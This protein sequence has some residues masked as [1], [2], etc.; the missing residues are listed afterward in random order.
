MKNETSPQDVTQTIC[1][2]LG[3]EFPSDSIIGEPPSKT[4]S[5][6]ESYLFDR[7]YQF[8]SLIASKL[9]SSV[10]LHRDLELQRNVVIKTQ[11]V[12]QEEDERERFLSECRI[13]AAFEHPG[14]IPIYDI[15]N[16]PGKVRLVMRQVE[17]KTLLDWLSDAYPGKGLS[18]NKANKLVQVFLEICNVLE[19]V[20]SK[21]HVHRDIKPANI[22]VGEFGKVFLIDWGSAPTGEAALWA[23]PTY[24]SPEQ[25]RGEPV[26]CRGDIFSLGATFFECLFGRPPLPNAA[27]EQLFE[28]RSRGEIDLP[29]PDERARVPEPL[30]AICLKGLEK[31]PQRRY[32][33]ASQLATDLANFQ[34]GLAVSAQPDSFTDFA[35]RWFS[36]NRSTLIKSAVVAVPFVILCVVLYQLLLRDVAHWGGAIFKD[37]FDSPTWAEQWEQMGRTGW[38]SKNG[39]IAYMSRALGWE[40]IFLKQQFST[41]IAVEFECF[42][43]NT[44]PDSP[45]P[46]DVTLV[47]AE[48]GALPGQQENYTLMQFGAYSNQLT[49][50]AQNSLSPSATNPST[51][52][53]DFAPHR[54]VP[55]KRHRFRVEISGDLVSMWVDRA[56]VLQTQLQ[57]PLKSGSL[58]F[59]AGGLG[60]KVYDNLTI[61]SRGVA[62]RA[63]ATLL[64]DYFLQ[65]GE[66]RQAER[67]FARIQDSQVNPAMIQEATF[68]R[69]LALWR[70]GDKDQAQKI[71]S[72][73]TIPR[74][75]LEAKIL[76]LGELFAQRDF[77][78]LIPEFQSTLQEFPVATT[79]KLQLFWA[80]CANQVP[81]S[82]IKKSEAQALLALTDSAKNCSVAIDLGRH[83]ILMG[84]E[85]F[86]TIREELSRNI[87]IPL[88]HLQKMGHHHEVFTRHA[89]TLSC[90][91]ARKNS[92]LAVEDYEG[93]RSIA[94]HGV[95][96][97]AEIC[98]QEHGLEKTAELFPTEKITRRYLLLENKQ[99]E[100]LLREQ[101]D[102]P[103]SVALALHSLNRTAEILDH[104]SMSPELKILA[105]Y[106]LL[107]E[108]Y[109]HGDRKKAL[110]DYL[111]TAEDID[112]KTIA[113]SEMWFE[114]Y[115]MPAFL[116]AH[117]GQKDAGMQRLRNYAA[118]TNNKFRNAQIPWHFIG[119]LTG[120]VSENEFKNQP[121]KARLETR[122]LLADAMRADMNG[123][124]PQAIELYK[125]FNSNPNHK[126]DRS[127][128]IQNFIDWR[129]TELADS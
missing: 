96:W 105:N 95:Q 99:F 62:E 76:N 113:H 41:P 97:Q 16:S 84:L 73:L 1:M 51:S 59:W 43:A 108:A 61:Y 69:G 127:I 101:A 9:G 58:G 91:G 128:F 7:R 110:A 33:S 81:G 67:E 72:L 103:L 21:G 53:V 18:K 111:Q 44:P 6:W 98:L 32:A 45:Q 129:I 104:P 124:N 48:G 123:D 112:N 20:H 12:D 50:I 79:K 17:G 31:N 75:V 55:G 10:A 47:W 42:L 82:L 64:G 22:M 24:M 117:S 126:K 4:S 49:I 3:E 63:P 57:A 23:T 78:R 14:I 54:L 120:Q 87:G 2:T 77:A 5:A 100:D 118:N 19:F 107:F 86:Q 52:V 88:I 68:K 94:N 27:R 25:A 26:D 80:S 85:E 106:A 34:A 83:S 122:K 11:F 8:L 28:R 89:Q 65:H 15:Q 66:F 46:S 125:T 60:N 119:Y 115:F 36:R 93:A 29:T 102:D 39:G 38:D 13:S 121:T 90:Y 114:H 116:L 35:L 37:S 70:S 56:L 92:M 40:S 74:Y 109:R 71:W 30:V